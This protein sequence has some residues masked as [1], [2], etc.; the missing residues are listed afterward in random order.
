LQKLRARALNFHRWLGRFYLLEV[1]L[2]SST[3]FAM[4][5]VSEQ[6]LPIHLGFGILAALWFLTVSRPI[7]KSA[8]EMSKRTAS[9]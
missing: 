7:A 4:A 3:G 1:L 2:G 6:G 5:L 8:A 9:G